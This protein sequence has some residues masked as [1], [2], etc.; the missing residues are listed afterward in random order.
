MKYALC[1]GAYKGKNV[2]E[3][4]EKVAEHGFHGLEYLNWKSVPDVGEL[5]KAQERLGVGISAVCTT[6]FNLVDGSLREQYLDGLRQTLDFCRIS[7]TRSIITQTGP[8]MPGISREKHTS[9]MVETLKRCASLCEEAGVV[10]E[11]EPLNGLV[12]HPGHFLQYS[13]ESAGI[14]DRVDSPFIKLVFDVYHQQI[15]EG[16]VIRN[17]V[18]YIDRINH[19]HIADN[20]GRKQPGTGEL[21]YLNILKAIKDTGYDGFVGLECG[22]TIDTDEALDQFKRDI[23]RQV[24]Q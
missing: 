18:A 15:T 2:I 10:L 19:F 9:D 7:G 14:I 24:E 12:N 13:G 17:A 11:L 6:F 4:L 22:Y 23:V 20:P 16:N 8:E 21:N 5:L 1:G 3:L